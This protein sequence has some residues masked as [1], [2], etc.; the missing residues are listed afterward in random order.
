MPRSLHPQ[1]QRAAGEKEVQHI[2]HLFEAE[3]DQQTLRLTNAAKNISF[4]SDGEAQPFF[5]VG[6]L[7]TVSPVEEGAELQAYTVAVS[8]CG[9]ND[10]L[11]AVAQQE[12]IQGRRAKIYLALLDDNSNIVGMPLLLFAGR[13]DSMQWQAG[14]NPSITLSVKNP[15]ADWERNKLRRYTDSDQKNIFPED[16][17]FE[18]LNSISDRS[19]TWGS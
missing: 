1:T 19:L 12:H 5:S 10:S 11:I 2:A 17:F 4:A 3:L 9:I 8:L 7:G 13:I 16:N 6:A 14:N 15:L 18:Y